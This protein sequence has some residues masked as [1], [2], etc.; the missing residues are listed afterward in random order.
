MR[1]A[2]APHSYPPSIGGA[3]L[4]TKGLAEAVASLGHQV[5]VISPDADSPEAFYE[6]GHR[7]VGPER[8]SMG[9]VPVERVRFATF[10]YRYW[11]RVNERK[12]LASAIRQYAQGLEASIDAFDPEV[13][14]TLPHLF[15][16]VQEAFELR[17]SGSWKLAYAPM[18]HEDDPYWSVEDV[19]KRVTAADAVIAL[20]EHEKK[21]LLDSY[22]AS[23]E[24]T[25][26]VP[27][28]VEVGYQASNGD[29]EA[30]VLFVGRRSPSKRLDVL[31]QAMVEVWRNHPEARLVIAGPPAAGG[32]DPLGMSSLTVDSRVDVFGTLDDEEKARLYSN[33][34]VAVTPSLTESFGLTTLEAWS[35]GTAVVAVG[36]PVNRSLISHGD[37]GILTNA[38]ARSLA[39]GISA[40]LQDPALA[41]QLGEN[42]RQ[43][44]ERKFTWEKSANALLSLLERL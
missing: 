8:E 34:L 17:R 14:V 37:D 38:D 24:S 13:V 4:Y 40:L 43:K 2:F 22:G 10:R 9:G 36:T 23:P 26:V 1:L 18:L 42:G 21:R 27:P 29:R 11:G 25:A 5:H 31:Y 7:P 30:I 35:H 12:A 3:E 44:V 39:E 33:A 20:T 6:L 41:E 16:N 15:P 19:E 28:G 32:P